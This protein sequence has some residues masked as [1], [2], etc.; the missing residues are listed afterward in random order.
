MK[1]KNSQFKKLVEA[2]LNEDT[3]D[4]EDELILY[5]KTNKSKLIKLLG[6]SYQEI[7]MLT[8]ASMCVAGRESSFGEWAQYKYFYNPIETL[9][10][11]TGIADPS[12][13]PTQAKYSTATD[14]KEY[15]D[16]IGVASP[17]DLSDDLKAMLST[18][19]ILARNYKKA[20]SLGYSK[21]RP[22]NI[23]ASISDKN[24]NKKF[25]STGSAALDLALCAYNGDPDKVI[26]KRKDKDY[27]PCYG[28]GCV[29]NEEGGLTTYHYIREVGNCMRKKSAY[30]SKF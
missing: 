13:G 22:G 16:E 8:I 27:I 7:K 28:D 12:I 24:A 30:Y 6:V 19:G 29:N 23:R 18:L 14:D 10:S 21:K 25:K 15:A 26:V 17:Y 3:R 4:Y 9:I 5:V 11:Y 20:A 2:F 1:I